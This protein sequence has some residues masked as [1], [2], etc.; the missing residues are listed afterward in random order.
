MLATAGGS[1]TFVALV[2]LTEWLEHQEWPAFAMLGSA[3]FIHGLALLVY[4]LLPKIRKRAQWPSSL[5]MKIW[6]FARGFASIFAL[7]CTVLATFFG[8]PAGDTM[9]LSSTNVFASAVAG[10]LVAQW[11]TPYP[12][13]CGFGFPYQEPTPKMGALTV[14]WLLGL[15]RMVALRRGLWQTEGR[16]ASCHWL[17]GSVGFEARAAQVVIGMELFLMTW[18]AFHAGI[19]RLVLVNLAP[20]VFTRKSLPTCILSG[21]G[22]PNSSTP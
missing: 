10:C 22:N 6:T 8:C 4:L 19:P 18:V 5:S 13:F 16:G 12:F 11:Y 9:A 14:L 2:V 20:S 3:G 1:L 17:W 7:A 15:P 21:S